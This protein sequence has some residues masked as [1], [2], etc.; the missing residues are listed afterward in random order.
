MSSVRPKLGPDVPKVITAWDVA[1]GAALRSLEGHSSEV[2]VV[3]LSP[4][5]TC[6][7]S[8]FNPKKVMQNRRKA[9]AKAQAA[10][11]ARA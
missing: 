6:L 11:A 2:N 3:V 1:T 7:A 4:D 10:G 5:G 9:A 8:C